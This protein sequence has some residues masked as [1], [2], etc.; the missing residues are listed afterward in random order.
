M[1]ELCFHGDVSCISSPKWMIPWWPSQLQPSKENP[2]Q[3]AGSAKGVTFL[4]G[5][6]PEAP[7]TGHSQ[8]LQTQADLASEKQA[9]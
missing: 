6:V 7:I 1:S 9:L 8:K 5:F 3:V 2:E 4:L